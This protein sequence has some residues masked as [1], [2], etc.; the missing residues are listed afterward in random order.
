MSDHPNIIF[1]FLGVSEWQESWKRSQRVSQEGPD[2]M[3][4]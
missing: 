1:T 3:Q 2:T 4:T